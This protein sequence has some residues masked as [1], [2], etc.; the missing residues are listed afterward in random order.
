MNTAMAH[1]FRTDSQ[2]P[3]FRQ[4]RDELVKRIVGS[5]PL[6]RGADC[7]IE[8]AEDYY[9]F[10]GRLEEIERRS[11]ASPATR[12]AVE[13]AKSTFIESE[14][15]RGIQ[16]PEEVE[17]LFCESFCWRIVEYRFL[18]RVREGIMAGTSR[19][20]QDQVDWERKLRKALV[21]ASKHL[22]KPVLQS[23]NW[24]GIRAR[25]RLPRI[26]RTTPEMLEEPLE[27]L[28]VAHE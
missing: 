3:P 7:P 17:G 5:A 23:D 26:R 14:H 16:D 1:A 25:R 12:L 28:E 21:P 2:C 11:I 27:V 8:G 10:L 6:F 9:H 13:A 19:S 24:S 15:R 22:L 20:Q 18:G 4:I